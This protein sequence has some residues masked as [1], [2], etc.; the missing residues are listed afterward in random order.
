MIAVSPVIM[1]FLTV[2]I[3]A[4]V[5]PSVISVITMLF[6]VARNV[7]AFIPVIMYKID[8]LI[9]GMIFMAVFAP[10]FGMSGWNTQIDR[11]PSHRYSAVNDDRLSV[12]ESRLR[13]IADINLTVK[14]R[15]TDTDGDT[16]IS[17]KG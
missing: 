11:S 4:M 1:V 9:T 13:E 15:L 2:F 12:N 16:D 14:T 10:M 6:L 7:F 5:I 3:S 17:G 8:A